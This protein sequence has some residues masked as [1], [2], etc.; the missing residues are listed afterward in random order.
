MQISR[1]LHNELVER[2][3]LVS[4]RGQWF[5]RLDVLPE[6]DAS[7]ALQVKPEPLTGAEHAALTEAFKA[8]AARPTRLTRAR[9]GDNKIDLEGAAGPS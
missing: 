3:L 8:Q 6:V 1:E 9:D 5:I 4:M 7:A 2:G